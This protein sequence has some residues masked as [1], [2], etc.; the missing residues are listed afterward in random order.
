M[1]WNKSSKITYSYD[2]LYTK[3]IP[4]PKTDKGWAKSQ[5]A[6]KEYIKHHYSVVQNDT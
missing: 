2:K 1:N 5:K 6:L 3:N 4:K